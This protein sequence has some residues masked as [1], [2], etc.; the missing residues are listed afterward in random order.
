MTKNPSWRAKAMYM[1]YPSWR[2][3]AMYIMFAFALVFG[4]A[5]AVITAAPASAQ[6]P[7]PGNQFTLVPS[8]AMNVKTADETFTVHWAS[9]PSQGQPVDGS[10]V[11]EWHVTHGLHDHT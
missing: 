4:L 9:G 7:T 8:L 6:T 5:A 10:L 3:K 11:L 2:A 1:M